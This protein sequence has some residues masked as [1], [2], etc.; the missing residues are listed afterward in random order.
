MAVERIDYQAGSVKGK[1]ALIWNE[2]VSGRRPL[3]L[4]MTNWLGV[5]EN[6]IKRAQ[7]MATDKYVAFVGCMYGEGKTCE[8]PPTSQEWMMAVRADRV[9]GRKRVNAALATMVTEANKRGIGDSSKKA[10][11][12]FCFG[13]G[14]V[15]A[16]GAAILCRTGSSRVSRAVRISQILFSN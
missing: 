1:G 6:A 10:T 12:G 15:L 5:T 9:E 11:V 3:L 2:N 7:K 13:G 4:V 14:N 16:L 8:G